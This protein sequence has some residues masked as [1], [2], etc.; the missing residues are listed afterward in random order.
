MTKILRINMSDLTTKFE[1]FPDKYKNL[2]GRA[3]TSTI[4]YDEVPPTCEPLGPFNKLIFAPGIVTGTN[5]PS[6]G[7]LSVGAKSP[8]TGGIKEA[9]AGGITAQKIARLGIKALILE[10]QPKTREKWFNIVITKDKAEI[11]EAN[12]FAGMGLYKLIAKVWEKYPNK[13]GIVGCGIAGQKLM[14]LAGIF[15]NN[16]ENNDPGRYA[17][18]GGL[19]AVIG[20]KQVIAII[21]DDTDGERPNP[22]DQ[23]LF[24]TGRKKLVAALNEHGVTGVLEKDGKAFGGLKNF[25]TNILQNIINEAGGLPTRNWRSGRFEGAAKISGEATHE[26]VD[27]VKTKFPDSPAAYAHSCHPGCIIRCSN[28]VPYEDT[29]KLQV[30]P[31]EYETAWA[32][33]TNCSID[34]H[35]YVSELN[36][37]CNDLGLDT[38]EAG[39]TI[40][41]AMEGGLLNFGD[42][43]AAVEFLKNVGTDS[44]MGKLIGLGALG[45]GQAIGVT[46][47]AHVKGQSLP[48]YDPRP[49]RGIGVTYATGPQGGDHTQGYTIAPE[50]LQVGGK[51][52]RMDVKKSELSRAFQATTAFIDSTGYCLFI[53]FA[54]L[55]IET[56]AVGMV[57]SIQGFLNDKSI[58]AVK[59]GMAV[60][61]TER[62]FNKKAGFTKAHDRLPEF[63]KNEPLPPH[64]VVFEVP[65]EELDKVFEA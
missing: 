49:I 2:G 65:D 53:A 3:L 12:E 48:A 64:N 45:I 33:G 35:Y 10:G 39:N 63:F 16:I 18:R 9:N 6:S 27:R 14:K 31:L 43:A 57:E 17:G 55:D 7:R 30:S 11:V 23:D 28:V 25:G 1:D 15:G 56:G 51:P 36:R 38:I 60:L 44:P 26:L 8:L 42:G 21:T 29:G 41:V 4:V 13:P 61:E 20:S 32:L 52:D 46:H 47:V 24:D 54:I 58:D 62:A 50:I 19:G 5:A 22:I 40:A 59:Y 37:V 34:S